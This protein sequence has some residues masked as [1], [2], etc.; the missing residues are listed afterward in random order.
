MLCIST[1]YDRFPMCLT[2]VPLLQMRSLSV[3]PGIHDPFQFLRSDVFPVIFII[4]LKAEAV[5]STTLGCRA[6]LLM[7][8][9]FS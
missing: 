3:P 5:I 8:A 2:A 7:S 4:L 1:F 9:F 6:L